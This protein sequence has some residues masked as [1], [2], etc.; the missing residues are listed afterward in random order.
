M[1]SMVI[2]HSYVMLCKRLPE[3]IST[4]WWF[5]TSHDIRKI[6]SNVP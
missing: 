2:F 4:G 1:N 6:P 5:Q 3:G